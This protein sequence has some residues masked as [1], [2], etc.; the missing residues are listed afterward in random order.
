MTR[1]VVAIVVAALLLG[2][3]GKDC[4]GGIGGCS[5]LIRNETCSSGEVFD[6]IKG[7]CVPK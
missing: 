7:Y 6:Q 5:P 1:T 4:P 2:G 3:C